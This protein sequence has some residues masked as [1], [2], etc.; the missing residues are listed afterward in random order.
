[1]KNNY[2]CLSLTILYCLTQLLWAGPV[3][4][5][6]IECGNSGLFNYDAQEYEYKYASE[7]K[8]W[9]NDVSD[10]AESKIKLNGDVLIQ[11]V[12]GSCQYQLK[13]KNFAVNGP[14]SSDSKNLAGQLEAN[15]AVFSIG[16][17]GALSSS[18]KFNGNEQNWVRNVK[19]AIISS[20]QLRSESELKSNDDASGVKSS[21]VYETDLFGRCRTTYRLRN[22]GGTIEINKKKA[23]HRCSLDEYRQSPVQGD[24][25]KSVAVRNLFKVLN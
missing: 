10:D 8:L 4:V 11:R 13:L 25:Y 20:F 9:I 21:V 7:T 2:F 15:V 1:M 19:R 16:S 14:S 23:L 22:V 24:E 12:A 3:P 5:R 17:N 18:V 6:E